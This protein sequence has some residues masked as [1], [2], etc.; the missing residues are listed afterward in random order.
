MGFL[1][2]GLTTVS[3]P[4]STLLNQFATKVHDSL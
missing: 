4:A 3:E 1:E 2:E